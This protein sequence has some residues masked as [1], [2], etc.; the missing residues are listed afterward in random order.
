[1]P[2]SSQIY[3]VI[4]PSLI[5]TFKYNGVV[6]GELDLYS[7]LLLTPSFACVWQLGYN[8]GIKSLGHSQADNDLCLPASILVFLTIP[9][10]V[11][12][13]YLARL[14]IRTPRS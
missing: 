14:C 11:R 7:F 4:I 5:V 2:D 12:Q 8:E 6:A 3:S 10:A 13:L 1:M 9:S